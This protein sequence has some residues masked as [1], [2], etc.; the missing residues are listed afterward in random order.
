MLIGA[1]VAVIAAGGTALAVHLSLQQS[2]PPRTTTQPPAS[3]QGT[4]DPE[5]IDERDVAALAPRGLKV[6][7]DQGALVRLRWALPAGARRYPVVLQRSPVKD[8]EQRITALAQGA[9]SA[10]VAGLDPD[11]GYCFVVGVPLR[12]AQS[13]TVAWSKPMCIRGAVARSTE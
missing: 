8:G 1:G 6:T 10:R 9:T 11:T 4:G 13:S 3:Q 7:A 5:H 12:I 2:P